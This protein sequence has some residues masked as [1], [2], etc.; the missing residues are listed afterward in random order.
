MDN[1]QQKNSISD[2]I[3]D[4]IKSGDIKMKPRISFVLKMALLAL[5]AFFLFFF[6]I[7]L[8]SFIIFSLRTSGVLFLPRFGFHGL[9][10]L[11]GSLPWVLVLIVAIL[12]VALEIFSKRFT[13]IYRRPIIY[14]LLIIIVLALAIGFLI[15]RTPF[16]SSLFLSARDRHLPVMGPFYRNLGAPPIHNVNR[17]IVSEITDNGFKIETSCGETLVIIVNP[18]THLYP[19]EKIEVGDEIVILGERNDGTVQ[20]FEIH[21]IEKDFN[22]FPPDRIMRDRPP[23]K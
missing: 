17:G 20:S 6:I 22:L 13:F 16:H 23:C 1:V 15:E 14:S 9:G 3:I 11:F 19:E 21:E 18:Q 7:Y 5:G 12:I 2:K 4:K 8:V 10:I